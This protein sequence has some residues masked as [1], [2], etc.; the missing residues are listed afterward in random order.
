MKSMT[1]SFAASLAAL[2]LTAGAAQA[3]EVTFTGTTV[4]CFG[5]GCTPG[6]SMATLNGLTFTGGSFTG[7]TVNGFLPI[8]GFQADGTTPNNFGSFALATPASGTQTYDGSVF[9]L[10]VSFSQPTVTP[11]PLPTFG[12]I[13]TGAV[14][15]N[16]A[17]GVSI[18]LSTA[19]MQPFTFTS[20]QGA[21]SGSLMIRSVSVN[22]GEQRQAISGNITASVVP[23]PATVALLGA[24]LLGLMGAGAARRRQTA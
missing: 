23:E 8:G 3:Q 5:A 11:N 13:L 17:G 16:G 14:T 1:R 7:T 6:T 10:F 15:S 12:Y 18:D 9:R 20:A 19:G 2:A 4:G 24:G 21:G 22:A